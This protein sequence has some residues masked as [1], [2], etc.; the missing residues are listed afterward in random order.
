MPAD[1]P[2]SQETKASSPLCAIRDTYFFAGSLPFICPLKHSPPL[3][4]CLNPFACARYAFFFDPIHERKEELP[5]I[6]GTIRG[7][8]AKNAPRTRPALVPSKPCPRDKQWVFPNG[9]WMH[10]SKNPYLTK[11]RGIRILH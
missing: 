9:V 5:E 1:F 6:G 4:L 11:C 2:K 8:C 3:A 7:W 10:S